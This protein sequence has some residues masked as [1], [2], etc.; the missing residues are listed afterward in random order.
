M[1]L[2]KLDQMNEISVYCVSLFLYI[3]IYIFV[4][5][6]M[7]I[8]IVHMCLYVCEWVYAFRNS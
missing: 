6:Y 3:F 5:I 4:C 1:Y 8:Y 7:F 2:V